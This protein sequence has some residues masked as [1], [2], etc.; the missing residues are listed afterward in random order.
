[1]VLDDGA[2]G[3]ELRA[4]ARVY[5]QFLTTMSAAA[6]VEHGGPLLRDAVAEHLGTAPDSLRVVSEHFPNYEHANVQ[7]AI[8]AYLAQ[9][10]RRGD[11]VGVGSERKR[12]MALSELLLA[13]WEGQRPPALG[14]VDM[15]N[16]PVAVDR[17]HACVQYG[18]YL[19]TDGDDRLVVSMRGQDERG[20]QQQVTLE[21][22]SVDEGRSRSLLA[23][24]RELVQ[25]R[26]AFRGQVLSLFPDHQGGVVVTFHE[27]PSIDRDR[28]VLADGVLDR[29]E[30]HTLG[31]AGQRDRLLRAGRHLKRGMLLHGPPGTGKTLT[32]TYLLNRMRGCTVLLLTGYGLRMIGP[33]C[34]LARALQ[35]AVVVLEDVD[36]VAEERTMPGAHSPLLFELL[37]EMDGIGEDADIVFLLTTNRADLLEPA[38]AARPGRIDLAVGVGLPDADGRRR[39]IRLYGEGL[40]LRLDDLD[41]VVERTDGV[42]AAFIKELLRK[43]ALIAADA[44]EDAADADGDGAAEGA[45]RSGP[46]VVRDQDLHAALD[47][48]LEEGGALTRLLLGGSVAEG[49]EDAPPSMPSPRL[50]PVA[51]GLQWLHGMP[52]GPSG[53]GWVSYGP[54]VDTPD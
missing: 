37:N 13:D 52:G 45:A 28:L 33:S 2:D 39:L 19:V 34:R 22:L 9:P 40:D 43:A 18:V 38:L 20:P 3:E 51:A 29:I 27:R 36:L 10:G 26:S 8:D 49:D 5:Q 30:R 48:L 47:E 46:L 21:V 12:Y 4:F 1:M 7:L 31:I 44:A 16:L 15:V 17:T 41:A 42:S 11:L 50:R 53:G 25:A 6:R 24:I 35:P 14:A 32:V 23:R 54:G